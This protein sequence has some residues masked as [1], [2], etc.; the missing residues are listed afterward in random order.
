MINNFF[1]PPSHVT[2]PWNARCNAEG[3]DRR[4]RKSVSDFQTRWEVA[5]LRNEALIMC[6]CGRANFSG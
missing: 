4:I 1:F 5:V 6:R 3:L 2:Q